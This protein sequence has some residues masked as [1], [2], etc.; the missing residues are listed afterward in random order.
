MPS[1][2]GR[3]TNIAFHRRPFQCMRPLPENQPD[4]LQPLLTVWQGAGLLNS[5][6]HGFQFPAV[7][8]RQF[9]QGGIRDRVTG[10]AVGAGHP[11]Q[12]R[13][14]FC[15]AQF[16]LPGT[17]F[18]V[19]ANNA[20]YIRPPV[21]SWAAQSSSPPCLCSIDVSSSCDLFCDASLPT[22]TPRA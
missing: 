4:H 11:C 15:A 18:R 8:L 13:G 1:F 22:E 21:V 17:Q 16:F 20:F 14:H 10:L 9:P 2:G 12:V 19:A 3:I 6:P 7:D 5:L